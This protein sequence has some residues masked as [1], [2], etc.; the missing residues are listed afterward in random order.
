MSD[1]TLK[2]T[3]SKQHSEKLNSLA[4]AKGISLAELIEQLIEDAAK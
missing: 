2:L 1:V 3:I 4:E